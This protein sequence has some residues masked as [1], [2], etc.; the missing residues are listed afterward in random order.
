M[1]QPAIQVQDLTKNYGPVVAVDRINFEVAPGE[2]V[3]FLGNNGAGKSTTMRVLTT[4]LPASSGYARVNGFDVMYQSDDVRKHLGYLPESVPLYSEMRVEEYLQYRAK[5]KSVDRTTRTKRIDYCL[6]RCRIKG[7]RRRLLGT[8]SKGYRQRVGLADTLL[9]DPK[10][11]ILDEPLSGLDPVQQEETLKAVKELGGQHTV[12]FSS[13]HLP[14]VEKVCDRVIIINRGRIK[15]DGKLSAIAASVPTVVVEARGTTAQ[16]EPLLLG[17]NGVLEIKPITAEAPAE[18]FA[19]FEVHA[20]PGLDVREKVAGRL[21]E[22]GHPIRRLEQRREKLE[23][24][25][26]RSA[27]RGE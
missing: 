3:G 15:F 27:M 21:H 12:L 8:L 4:F 13:H 22:K 19:A 5:L 16:L 14:D 2:L 9:A 20:E 17:I 18:G 1:T 7:V 10:V 24:I 25:Y 26:M 6:D 11:L 23:D